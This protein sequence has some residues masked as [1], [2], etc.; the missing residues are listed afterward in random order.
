MQ[1]LHCNPLRNKKNEVPE[2]LI[3][4]FIPLHKKLSES[5]NIPF[6]VITTMIP[7]DYIDK[8]L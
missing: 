6:L 5:S 7:V 8:A 1:E 2:A 3:S 4:L